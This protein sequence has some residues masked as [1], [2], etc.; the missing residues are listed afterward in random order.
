MNDCAQDLSC[1]GKNL[2]TI[3]QDLS[4]KIALKTQDIGKLAEDP[5][6]QSFIAKTAPLAAK[7]VFA[8]DAQKK[9]I[10]AEINKI[11]QE[12]AYKPV[13]DKKALYNAELAKLEADLL[14][15]SNGI[16]SQLK[17]TGKAIPWLTD[18]YLNMMS[19]QE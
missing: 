8:G 7:K 10:D 15:L 1:L 17:Y 18:E 11:S 2:A 16:G 9:E 5:A 13:M 14:V 12:P 19:I 4:Q 6:M 3:T